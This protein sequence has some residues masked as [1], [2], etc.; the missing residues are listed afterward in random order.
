[1]DL[2]PGRKGR[3]EVNSAFADS[4][5]QFA[6]RSERISDTPKN[7]ADIASATA[8]LRIW[9]KGLPVISP[10]RAMKYHPLFAAL[11]RAR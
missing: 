4:Y 9:Y 5:K 3:I 8:R 10:N 11:F 7:Q 1:V 2:R 6:F